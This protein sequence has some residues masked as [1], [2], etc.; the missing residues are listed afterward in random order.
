M[1]F[2]NFGKLEELKKKFISSKTKEMHAIKVI[3]IS[4]KNLKVSRINDFIKFSVRTIEL[5]LIDV[6]P[7]SNISKVFLLKS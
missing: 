6:R 5:F 4:K 3:L 2:L 7:F 1:I